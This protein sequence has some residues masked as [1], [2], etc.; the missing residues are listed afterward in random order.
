MIALD[1]S[2]EAPGH[3]PHTCGCGA[4]LTTWRT[5][6][7]C[8]SGL[9]NSRV[10]RIRVLGVLRRRGIATAAEIAQAL[11]QPVG[12]VEATLGRLVERGK[13]R[14]P[15]PGRYALTGGSLP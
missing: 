11:T 4:L 10:R 5:C 13:V 14:L 6:L 3:T 2:D 1:C 9:N 15:Y 12:R 8:E 7:A